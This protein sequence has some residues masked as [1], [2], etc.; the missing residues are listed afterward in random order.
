M[1][2]MLNEVTTG[3]A[4]RTPPVWVSSS[5]LRK[6]MQLNMQAVEP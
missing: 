2:P 3:N 6:G 5:G 4:P 1:R